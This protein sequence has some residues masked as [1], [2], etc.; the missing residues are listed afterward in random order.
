MKKSL[1]LSLIILLYIKGVNL[2]FKLNKNTPYF[3]TLKRHII[4]LNKM[5]PKKLRKLKEKI[6]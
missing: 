4:L 2:F 5:K 1:K 6:N 3:I